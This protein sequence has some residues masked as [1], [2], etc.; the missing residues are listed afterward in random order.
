MSP[1]DL[2][3]AT[4]QFFATHTLDAEAIG[5]FFNSNFIT[6]LVGALAGAGAG[7]LA[8]QR[9]VERGK[10]R[11]ELL[12]EMRN[13]NAA[14]ALAFSVANTFLALKNQHVKALKENF[15]RQKAELEDFMGKRKARTIPH[16]DPF[17]FQADLQTLVPQVVPIDTLKQLVFERLSL[18]GRALSLVTAIMQVTQSIEESLNKRNDLIQLYRR[19]EATPEKLAPLY[20]G[21]QNEYGHVDLSYPAVVDAI[22]SSNDDGIFFS[23]LLCKDLNE[24]GNKLSEEFKIKFKDK[25]PAIN[26]VRFDTEKAKTL[27]PTQDNYADWL[28]CFAK[29]E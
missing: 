7:A 18:T 15:D 14:I 3:Q 9:I 16:D 4:G 29:K 20:F 19:F 27:I 1:L 28:S 10:H 25:P 26:E 23:Q 5:K 8:A 6:S 22:Y 13:T 11:D 21:L 24:H 2:Y 17:S 12:H